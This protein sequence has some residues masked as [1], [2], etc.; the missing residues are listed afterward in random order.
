MKFSASDINAIPVR[1][2]LTE[3]GIPA[4]SEIERCGMEDIYSVPLVQGDKVP[5]GP[6]IPTPHEHQETEKLLRPSLL[7]RIVRGLKG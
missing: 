2:S 4:A 3:S 7:S 1:P 5:G 6:R